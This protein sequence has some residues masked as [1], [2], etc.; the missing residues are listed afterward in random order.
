MFSC[1][2]VILIFLQFHWH[3][4][5]ETLP[6]PDLIDNVTSFLISYNQ[7]QLEINQNLAL[8][9]WDYETNVSDLTLRFQIQADKESSEY[10]RRSAR[11]ASVYNVDD[12]RSLPQIQR[13]LKF[14]KTVGIDLEPEEAEKLSDLIGKMT[15]LYA[16]TTICGL[17]DATL[18]QNCSKRW[19]LE[20]QIS[21]FMA[22]NR[23]YDAL[24]KVWRAWYEGAGRPI[25]NF[26]KDFVNLSNKG[27]KTGGFHD[28]GAYW[29]WVYEA[30]DLN[31]QVE[32][33][34]F[35]ILPLYEQLHTYTRKKLRKLYNESKFNTSAIPAHLLGNMWA[36]EWQNLESVL[37]P[38]P[39]KEHL[40][41]TNAMLAQNYTV[42]KMFRMGDEFFQSLGMQKLTEDFWQ[43]SMFKKPEDGREVVCH[44]SASD[45]FKRGD[46]RIKMCTEVD[47]NYFTT[48]HHELGHIQ[49]Y[50]QYANLPTIFRSGANPGFHE[51]IGDT[52][53]LSV[54]T[55]EHLQTVG[56][57]KNYK[58]D[59]E[60]DL[61]YLMSVALRYIPF[62]P[63]GFL[64]DKWRYGVFDG[65][66]SPETWN[67]RWWQLAYK[68][69]GIV[70]PHK[71]MPEDFDPAAKFHVSSNTEYLRYFVAFV[72]KFQFYEAMCKAAKQ[73]GPLHH[74]DFY[75][76][77]E[78]GKLLS[79]ALAQGMSRPWPDLLQQ[80][81]GD[82]KMN[83]QALVRYF[84]PLR[85]W[86]QVHN[87]GEC[88]GWGEEWPERVMNTLPKSRCSLHLQ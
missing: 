7:G 10:A 62:M 1:Y 48:V 59:L 83:A 56:L 50:L 22:E 60:Q 36:Q 71:M 74:C 39:Q 63:F 17:D 41:V 85:K 65:S 70:A 64:V 31:E 15:G 54:G 44:A 86:L 2:L 80:M 57:L 53:A 61:N 9:Y 35:E 51:A 66:F 52:I 77:Q 14:V 13:Q 19:N 16:K 46:V 26:Y 49:Y 88:F 20:P 45:M 68:Y 29:R 43:K 23:N 11:R 42:L 21:T 76:S 78:A 75:K 24:L 34:F 55:P 25:K 4:H 3:Q 67:S 40:N 8:A 79:R 47:I 32:Q 33:L 73:T 38:F 72:L 69:Q 84:E 28:T 18:K 82:R 37:R 12:F 87:E 27:A 58:F 81:T 6:S 5:V 30:A